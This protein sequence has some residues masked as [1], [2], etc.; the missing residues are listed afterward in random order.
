MFRRGSGNR[1]PFLRK[2]R[3]VALSCHRHK[4]HH[5]SLRILTQFAKQKNTLYSAFFHLAAGTGFEPVQS[6]SESL[7]LPLHHPAIFNL[8]RGTRLELARYKPH[9]PQTCASADSATL[10]NSQ[11]HYYNRLFSICQLFFRKNIGLFYL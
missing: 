8:V 10:A 9:A 4:I 6:E 3:L 5:H 1:I 7:V 2:S 11:L